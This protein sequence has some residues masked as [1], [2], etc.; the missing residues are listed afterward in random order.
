MNL[1]IYWQENKRLLEIALPL[2]AANLVQSSS[3]FIGTLLLASLGTDALAASGLVASLYFALVVVFWGM[4][5]GI[6]VLI[7]QAHGANQPDKI[8]S[9]MRQGM[10]FTGLISIPMMLILWLVPGLLSYSVS[11]TTILNLATQYMHAMIW[12]IVPG[13]CLVLV[14]QLLIGLQRS[15]IV[16]LLSLMSVPL[17][18]IASYVLMFGKWGFP[19]YGVQGLGYGLAFAYASVSVIA[20]VYI[21][22][23][24][25]IKSYRIFNQLPRLEWQSLREIFRIGW[26]IGA[27]YGVEVSLFATLALCMGK[28]GSIALDAHQIVMQFMALEI[29]VAFALMQATSISVGYAIGRK[30]FGNL[31]AIGHVGMLQAFSIA[32]V[33]GVIYCLFPNWLVGLDIRYD[34]ANSQAIL[35][36][37]S[38]LL[39]IVALFQI[40][41]SVRIVAM[42]ALRGMK[43]TRFAM[44]NS[45][46]CFWGIGFSLSYLFGFILDYKA[47]GLWLGLTLG[48]CC[49]ALILVMRYQ[50][51]AKNYRQDLEPITE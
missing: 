41:E 32:L 19:K 34:Q 51:L 40:V 39:V 30:D 16:M 38:K 26:P 46:L 18:I 2:I 31:T 6:A 42:G 43:D 49:G 10:F 12:I 50:R 17:E 36:L 23:Q 7:S 20:V 14:E 3:G 5:S 27:M 48:L 35:A 33:V 9:L 1:S 24:N 45:L 29:T 37:T 13:S 8:S 11:D 44:L 47:V 4:L 22:W 28:L 21:S 15:S 25:D